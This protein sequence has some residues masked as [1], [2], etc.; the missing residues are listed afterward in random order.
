MLLFVLALMHVS[1]LEMVWLQPTLL[2]VFTAKLKTFFLI[3]QRF[4]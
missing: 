4:N 3:K 2:H 1:V